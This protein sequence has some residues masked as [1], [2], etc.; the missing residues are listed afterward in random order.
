VLINW[1]QHTP[2]AFNDFQ[3][4]LAVEAVSSELV[5]EFPRIRE[6]YRD[7]FVF[8]DPFLKTFRFFIKQT[9]G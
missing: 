2:L 6:K 7:F 1:G 9:I 5:S 8:R 4:Q 3:T